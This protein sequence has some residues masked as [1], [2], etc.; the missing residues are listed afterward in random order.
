M[1]GAAR[2]RPD[3]ERDGA[4][5]PN[6][7]NSRFVT[8][9]GLTWHVQTLGAG[10]VLLLL[11]GTGASTHS[12]RALAPI[13]ARDFSVIAPDLPGHGF[14]GAP[15][16]HL[17]S[18]P[19]MARAIGALLHLL[20]ARPAIAVGHSA[21]AA[22]LARMCIDATIAPAALVSLNGAMLPMRGVPG[23]FFSPVAKLLAALPPVPAMVA[24]R[25]ADA[26]VIERLI[27]E[28]GSALE[29]EGL[30][31]Y[32]RLA[33]SPGHVA[34]T[35]AMMAHWDL[36]PLA[37]DLPR[38]KAKLTL[39]TGSND[40]TIPPVD[41]QRIRSLLPDA[42]RVSLPGLGHLAHEERPEEVAAIVV[43]AARAARV[44]AES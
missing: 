30:A 5:W 17:Q 4:D 6:R 9:G 39:V 19:G 1:I 7:G 32:R 36:R 34:G 2:A 28:T 13:L 41:A 18:L 24:R 31:L 40:R 27:R 23:Q 43:A 20:D 29:P 25:A 15:A 42:A 26:S 38:L 33:R 10:P 44:L 21:G 11:H 3:W 12:W 8:A 16:P 37:R 22:I 14:T 35:L